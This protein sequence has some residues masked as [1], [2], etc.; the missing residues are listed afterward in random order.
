MPVKDQQ[1][2]G[3]K[4]MRIHGVFPPML[5]PFTS[6]GDVDEGCFTSNIE[7]WNRTSL[8]GYVV[9]GSN[10]EAAYLTEAEKLRLIELTSEHA[11]SDKMVVAGTGVESTHETVHLTNEAARRGAHAA[12]VLTPSYYTDKMDD[13]A[14]IAHFTAV[15][16]AAMIPILLYNV[17]KFTHVTISVRAIETLAHHPNIVGMKDSSG[18]VPRLTAILNVVPDRFNLIVGTAAAW[19]P[20]IAL[21]M[22]AGI[23]AL[24]NC[25]PN[26]SARVLSLFEEGKLADAREL[27]NRL[28]ALNAAIT[29]TYGVAGLKHAAEVCGYA[30]GAVR[31]PLQPLREE[32]KQ[33]IECLCREAGVVV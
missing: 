24:A 32:E 28:F 13:R 6:R 33:T 12:L 9:L 5:T 16:D 21:G 10:S 29:A 11:A 15:A 8:A 27:H 25:A 1:D 23:L 20:A 4:R 18:D 17:P 14:L 31:S 30:G 26:E 7:K 22:R 19:F 3:E 2:E